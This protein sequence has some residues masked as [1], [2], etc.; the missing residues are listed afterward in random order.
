MAVVGFQILIIASISITYYFGGKQKALYAS[1]FW[2][3]WTIVLLFFPPLIIIQLAFIWVTFLVCRQISNNNQEIDRLKK[4]ISCYSAEFQS[5][6]QKHAKGQ[7]LEQICGEDHL[8]ELNKAIKYSRSEVII[9]SGWIRSTIINAE[10][11]NLI[12]QA[13]QRSVKFYIGYGWE[14]SKGDH[15]QDQSSIE[16]ANNLER[17]KTKYPNNL[18]IVKFANH[19]KILIKDD[20]YFICGSNNWL[21]NR[22]FRNSETSIK[23]PASI[24]TKRKLYDVKESFLTA[25]KSKSSGE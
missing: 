21:S 1:I 6:I 24:F 14:D 13:I 7:I 18:F 25:F 4:A 17:L 22:S 9:L 3:L 20:D 11:I 16:A 15:N 8:N 2:S 19:Q 12:E 10:F 23:I 5:D